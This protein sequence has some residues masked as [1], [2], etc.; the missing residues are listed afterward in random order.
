MTLFK[1]M[2]YKYLWI[3]LSCATFISFC[4]ASW[5]II[6]DWQQHERCVIRLVSYDYS[7]E[8]EVNNCQGGV[9]CI[10]GPSCSSVLETFQD[11]YSLRDDGF[12]TDVPLQNI[13]SFFMEQ[14][15]STYQMCC[16][17]M[18]TC[19]VFLIYFL[20]ISNN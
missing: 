5:I 6:F 3:G 17:D 8:W 15:P 4:F 18:D 16:S 11:I 12:S 10:A 20:S 7:L 9:E 1:I 2:N 13:T 19:Q 14:I